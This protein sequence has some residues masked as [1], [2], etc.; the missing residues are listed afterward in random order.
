M[1]AFMFPS[2]WSQFKINL[3]LQIFDGLFTYHVLTL[4]VPE[5]NPL[6]RDAIS[7][8]G[9]VWGL[10]YWKLLACVLL[11]LIFVLRHFRES[12]TLKALTLT[13]AVYGCLLVVSVY[14]F[15]AIYLSSLD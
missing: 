8:W 4:G 9:E 7:V 2:I 1:A 14:H 15:C 3:L 5:L 11:G 13:S 12:L 6:V 10:V